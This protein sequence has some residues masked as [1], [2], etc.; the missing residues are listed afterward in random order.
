M[1]PAP[2]FDGIILL[3]CV[4]SPSHPNYAFTPSFCS[5]LADRE[6]PSIDSMLPSAEGHCKYQSFGTTPRWWHVMPP[7]SLLALAVTLPSIRA[8]RGLHAAICRRPLQISIFCQVAFTL[9]SSRNTRHGY[10]ADIWQRQTLIEACQAGIYCLWAVTPIPNILLMRIEVCNF[11]SYRFVCNC[12]RI[13]MFM[14]FVGLWAANF[15]TVHSWCLERMKLDWPTIWTNHWCEGPEWTYHLVTPCVSWTKTGQEQW[16]EG[17][18]RVPDQED[19]DE[20]QED[21]GT[22]KKAWVLAVVL[23]KDGKEW[24]F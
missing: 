12:C 16:R 23:D 13:W 7:S 21:E 19:E 24:K 14:N 15:A 10:L 4:T 1:S 18:R 20:E 2:P 6:H 9:P 11:K 17:C 8:S 5:D 22:T 3:S